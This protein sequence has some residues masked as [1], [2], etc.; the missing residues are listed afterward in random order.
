VVQALAEM[1]V[2]VAPQVT[3]EIP[4]VQVTLGLMVVGGLA[5]LVVV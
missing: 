4:E 2:L 3:Q 5:D 1:L